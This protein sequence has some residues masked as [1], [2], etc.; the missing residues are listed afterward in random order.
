MIELK[1]QGLK[2]IHVNQHK[3]RERVK[4]PTLETHC[5]TVKFKGKTYTARQVF[6]DGDSQLV[7]RIHK[8][9]S[10]GARLWLE[11]TGPVRLDQ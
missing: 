8:P 7:D 9:L 6:I 1:Q 4:D 3:L 5:Y 2:R 10:C 11:T